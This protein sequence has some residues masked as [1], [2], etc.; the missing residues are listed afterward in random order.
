MGSVGSALKEFCEDE[1]QAKAL[2]DELV[3][4]FN[5]ALTD[6]GFLLQ[7]GGQKSKELRDQLKNR[8]NMEIIHNLYTQA[9][10]QNPV[11]PDSTLVLC[12]SPEPEIKTEADAPD[13]QKNTCADVVVVAKNLSAFDD[14]LSILSSLPVEGNVWTTTGPHP[15]RAPSKIIFIID[16]LGENNGTLSDAVSG[17]QSLPTIQLLKLLRAKFPEDVFLLRGK[18][19]GSGL[20]SMG[21]SYHPDIADGYDDEIISDYFLAKLLPT[22]PPSAVVMGEALVSANAAGS[23]QIDGTPAHPRVH[24]TPLDYATVEDIQRGF[25]GHVAERVPISFKTETQTLT[26]RGRAK[27]VQLPTHHIFSAPFYTPP[28]HGAEDMWSGWGSFAVISW[29]KENDQIQTPKPNDCNWSF[30]KNALNNRCVV[31]A[32]KEKGLI[33]TEMSVAFAPLRGKLGDPE[34]LSSV[35]IYV[36]G[37]GEAS[38]NRQQGAVAEAFR[39]SEQARK[40]Q[41]QKSLPIST[42]LEGWCNRCG[43][44]KKCDL[45]SEVENQLRSGKPQDPRPISWQAGE[46]VA[47]PKY[48]T[49][50]LSEASQSE[51]DKRDSGAN[52]STTDAFPESSDSNGA[53]N[54]PSSAHS[55]SSETAGTTLAKKTSAAEEFQQSQASQ[56]QVLTSTSTSETSQQT[57]AAQPCTVLPC[58]QPHA[59]PIVKGPGDTRLLAETE[60]LPGTAMVSRDVDEASWI[61]SMLLA[62]VLAAVLLALSC[63][64]SR[65]RGKNKKKLAEEDPIPAPVSETKSKSKNP[66]VSNLLTT[67]TDA[68]STNENEG[69]STDKE[70][71]PSA[72]SP[73]AAD[74]EVASPGSSAAKN[75]AHPSAAKAAPAAAKKKEHLFSRANRNLKKALELRALVYESEKHSASSASENEDTQGTRPLLHS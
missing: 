75:A 19:D 37:Q 43:S 17:E 11:Q 32:E 73:V 26:A 54:T 24:I 48:A 12:A 42:T 51:L 71:V 55:F 47:H 57:T 5:G 33:K 23:T 52:G 20:Q 14:T 60:G 29:K 6:P 38:P 22:L 2:P 50:F 44:G 69:S 3:K 18:S 59:A 7:D 41:G 27:I 70:I 13:E 9:Q 72:S 4:N 45:P 49:S 1:A 21:D 34:R 16:D 40:M 25:R 74:D 65:W 61:F 67:D 10:E 64:F 30:D 66:T 39:F 8:H 58:T 28:N 36:Y 46:N 56:S 31:I 53:A 68:G 35:R 63:C 15:P 62:L